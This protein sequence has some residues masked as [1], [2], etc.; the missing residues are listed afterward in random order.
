MAVPNA[1][2]MSFAVGGMRPPPRSAGAGEPGEEAALGRRV[3]IVEDELMVAW[4]L[5][6]MVED[7]G[8]DVVGTFSRGEAALAEIEAGGADIVL[9]DINLGGAGLDGVETAQRLL[10]AHACRVIFISAYADPATQ[11]RVAEM[12]P[13]APLL[14]K[15]ISAAQLAE[16]LAGAWGRSH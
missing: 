11:A 14:R 16:A 12:V 4:S 6:T 1:L 5:E 10:Q 2:P 9:M 3:S 15:P 7:L 13:G 8:Y